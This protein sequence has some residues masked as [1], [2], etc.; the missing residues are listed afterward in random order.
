MLDIILFFVLYLFF[1]LGTILT[2]TGPYATSHIAWF[3]YAKYCQDV[4]NKQDNLHKLPLILKNY[5]YK[6]LIIFIIYNFCS[7]GN[8]C[9]FA[10]ILMMIN[11]NIYY[12]IPLVVT[13]LLSYFFLYFAIKTLFKKF[14]TIGVY[15]KTEAIS[16]FKEYQASLEPNLQVSEFK[17]YKFDKVASRNQPF[18]FNQ[19][20]YKG[21][22]RRLKKK[23]YSD[24]KYNI[25]LLNMYIR[26]LKTYAAFFKS[27]EKN[28]NN[29]E[30][31]VLPLTLTYAVF[32]KSLEKNLRDYID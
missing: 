15:N 10:W 18:Q 8:L 5:K 29:L 22:I 20:R 11:N 13:F 4:F 27:L 30:L 12:I 3:Q 23:N 2:I 25:K 31:S 17:L 19:W 26:Y 21:K 28:F 9:T 16:N 1:F 6:C 14:E 7:V 24:E 32:F